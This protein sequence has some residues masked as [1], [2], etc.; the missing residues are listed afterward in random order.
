MDLRQISGLAR[1]VDLSFPTN[2]W[3]TVLTGAA[4]AGAWV[5][6]GL[7]TGAW[8]MAGGWAALAALALFLAWALARELDPGAELVAFI[9]AGLMLPFLVLAGLGWLPL[10]D[11]AALFIVLLAVRVL[12]RTT[13]IAATVLDG[14]GVLALGLWLALGG[15]PV[16]LAGACAALLLDGLLPPVTARRAL[17]AAA[18]VAVAVAAAVVLGQAPPS[19]ESGL[20]PIAA[21]LAIGV[22]FAASIRA[23]GRM[24]SIGDATG[25]PLSPL[26]VRAGQLL[27]LSIGLVIVL[28]QGGTGLI[29]LLPLWAAMVA[30]GGFRSIRRLSAA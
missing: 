5:W 1:P 21:G 11:I 18:A 29:A 24:E 30:L 6:R 13:G 17:V 10:P 27:A 16:Y 7:A 28:W 22:L 26:R 2:R 9:A 23:A 20:L 19:P 25:E 8:L 12:N 3:I 15:S 4:L 14:V